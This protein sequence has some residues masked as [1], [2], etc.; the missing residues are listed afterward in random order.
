MVKVD[1]YS[2][3]CLLNYSYF[4]NY[5]KMTAIDLSKQ[6]TLDADP[7]VIQQV[8]FTRNRDWSE[9]E[10]MFFIIQ[11]AKKAVL[12]ILRSILDFLKVLWISSH[13]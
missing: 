11:K 12:D 1:D 7:K 10:T 6:E 8:S 13:K 2:T 4:I 5:Y 3:G 9:S